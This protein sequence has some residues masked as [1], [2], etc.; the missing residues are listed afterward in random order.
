MEIS[1]LKSHNLVMR[2]A[3]AVTG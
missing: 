3:P 1:L 2:Q